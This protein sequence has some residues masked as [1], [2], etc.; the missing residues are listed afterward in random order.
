LQDDDHPPL[1][2]NPLSFFDEGDPPP[3]TRAPRSARAGGARSAAAGAADPETLRRRRLAAFAGAVLFLLVVGLLFRSCLDSRAEDRLRDY[4]RSVAD[5]V[6]RSDRQVSSPF[7]QALRSGGDRPVELESRVNRLAVTARGHTEQAEDFDVPDDLR[8]A[9]RNLL[10]SLDLRETGLRKVAGR[11][12]A[13]FGRG[14]QE[15]SR[16][17][18]TSIA[19]EMQAFLASDVIYDTRVRPFIGQ[20]LDDEE[21]GGQSIGDTRFLPSLGWLDPSSVG[22]QLGREVAGDD[23]AAGADREPAPG[24]HGHALTSVAVGDETLE[25]GEAINRIPAGARTVFAV[26]FANQ[27]DNDETN[28]PVRVRIRG[29]GTRTISAL[30]RVPRT[31]AGGDAQ[32]QV[33]ITQAPPIGQPVEVEVTVQGV[34][35]EEL[36][37]NNTQ[38]YTVIF[39]R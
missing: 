4:N 23:A 15:A 20:A 25:P 24:R 16:D 39:E 34:P 33:P 29:G 32:A 3:R 10:L 6:Q 35:G 11:L 1:G 13:A 28:V 7:F 36:T 9:H 19:A 5:V 38:T 12:R 22:E 26:S 2:A 8:P 14:E 37:D 27:G 30:R 17:A 31:E 21:I 18:I